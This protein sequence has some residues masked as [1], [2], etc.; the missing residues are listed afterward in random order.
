MDSE[1]LAE[2]ETSFLI[3]MQNPN[4]ISH[5]VDGASTIL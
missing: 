3:V 5:Q 1:M 2:Q 4:I